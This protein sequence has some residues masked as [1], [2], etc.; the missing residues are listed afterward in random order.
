MRFSLRYGATVHGGG[1]GRTCLASKLSA[2]QLFELANLL[3]DAATDGREP[4]TPKQRLSSFTHCGSFVS[5][6]DPK[7]KRQSES[8]EDASKRVSRSA[9][10][11]TILF[12]PGKATKTDGSLIALDIRLAKTNKEAPERT[13][14]LERK[15][16]DEAVERANALTLQLRE[17][18]RDTKRRP[19]GAFRPRAAHT[20][21]RIQENA[22]V[23]STACQHDIAIGFTLRLPPHFGSMC[24]IALPWLN[25]LRGGME[26]TEAVARARGAAGLVRHTARSD[27][28][29]SP[30][31]ALLS[32]LVARPKPR[33]PYPAARWG[34][35]AATAR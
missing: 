34:F 24:E 27:P 5:I 15:L 28:P 22:F 30:P 14:A 33:I 3:F 11:S 35:Q 8:F 4:S 20:S 13:A 10:A 31:S 18:P 23:Y 7:L 17:G 26:R 29:P 6:V 1:V 25:I 21:K 2:S 19:R 32:A 16:Y 9:Q 12:E